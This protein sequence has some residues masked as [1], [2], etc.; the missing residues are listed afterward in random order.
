MGATHGNEK[1]VCGTQAIHASW[2]SST[3][4]ALVHREPQEAAA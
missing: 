3:A 2:P 4:A 1:K